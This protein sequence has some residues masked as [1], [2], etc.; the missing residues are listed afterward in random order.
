[1][2]AQTTSDRPNVLLIFPDQWRGDCLSCLGH[3]D[4]DTPNLDDL[5]ARGVTFTHAYTPVTTCIAAR[6]CLAMG[7]TASTTGRLGYKDGVP[8]EFRGT[9]ME[10]L[11]DSGYQT[12]NVGKT[13]FFPDRACLGFE[14]N[15]LFANEPHAR[16]FDPDFVSDYHEWLRQETGGRVK[17]STEKFHSNGWQVHTWTDEEYLHP[18]NWT[19]QTAIDSL[20]RRDPTRPFFLQVGY[21]RPHPPLD[22]PQRYFD[23]YNDR[24][25]SEVPIGDWAKQHDVPVDGLSYGCG[26][27]AD[28]LLERTRKAYFAQITAL[29]FEIGRIFHWLQQNRL[30]NDTVILFA[31]DHGEM[32]GDH[33]HFRKTVPFEGSA[34]IPFILKPQ[35]DAGARKGSRCG[36]PVTLVDVMPSLL[37]LTG[38]PIPDHV[39]GASVA[40]IVRGEAERIHDWVHGE[41]APCWQWIVDDRYKYAWKSDSGNEWLFDLVDDPQELINLVAVES[42]AAALEQC[43]TRLVSVLEERPGDGLAANGALIVGKTLP[44][45]R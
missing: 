10:T 9:M 33:H 12:I 44:S 16:N 37:E 32:L 6:S 34:K 18:N 5:S 26:H 42:H 13:H 22:P 14:I 17:A 25:I 31:S 45:V 2:N 27:L 15:H 7:Q 1:M 40:P 4:V 36:T 8:W 43:R 3:P 41:H 11:R 38:T 21:H 39:E 30:Y 19:T 35:G 28:H 20:K 23:L 29:D 24:G